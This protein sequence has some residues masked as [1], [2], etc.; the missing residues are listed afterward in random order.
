MPTVTFDK[1]RVLQYIGE[2]SDE[3]LSDRISMIGTDLEKVSENEIVVEIFPNRPDMLSEEG[4]AHAIKNFIGRGEGFEEINSKES[5]YELIVSREMKSVRPYTA[6]AVVKNLNLDDES[7]RAIIQLQE[8]LDMTYCRRRKKAAIGIYPL[9]K[10]NWPIHFNAKRPKEIVYTPLEGKK[11]SA[12]RIIEEHPT[13]KKYGHLLSGYRLFPVFEDSSG[14]VLSVPPI[15]N[16]EETGRVTENTKEVFIEVSGFDLKT[17]SRVLNIIL[18]SFQKMGAQIYDVS[19]KYEEETILFPERISQRISIKIS[20]INRMLGLK[21]EEKEL[22][23]LLTRMGIGYDEKNKEAIVPTYRTDMMHP[24][25]IAEDVA[26]AYGYENFK[27]TIPDVATVAE[28][29]ALEKFKKKVV[30][31]LAGLGLQETSSYSLVPLRL[32]KKTAGVKDDIVIISNP[33]NIEYDSLRAN[34]MPSMLEILSRNRHA[35]MPRGIFE[36]GRT[37][38]QADSETGVLEK[39]ELAVSIENNNVTYTDIRQ[40]AEALLKRYTDD[41]EFIEADYYAHELFFEGRR[42][43]I[44]VKGEVVGELG[45]TNPD[46]LHELEIENPVAIMR[47]DMDLLHSLLISKNKDAAANNSAKPE[48]SEE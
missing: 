14:A 1:K 39:Y 29:N 45:E 33:M 47:I 11:M 36:I 7:L 18:F 27:A 38:R 6:A 15:V 31:L 48:D 23:Q 24:I 43:K 46:V 17:L 19:V 9:E 35:S 4:F 5:D 12:D 26:I 34:L 44:K 3:E 2:I 30:Y 42:A 25:D 8:K 40:I 28:E 21:I 16:S 41:Y 37:F 32:Q 20:Y 10:I 22:S 13:G